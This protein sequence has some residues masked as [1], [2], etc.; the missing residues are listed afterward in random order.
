MLRGIPRLGS[1]GNVPAAATAPDRGFARIRREPAPRL[2]TTTVARSQSACCLKVATALREQRAYTD[3]VQR[4]TG[5]LSR[6]YFIARRQADQEDGRDL[7][8]SLRA[9]GSPVSSSTTSD[10][11]QHA[12]SSELECPSIGPCGSQGTRPRRCFGV[13]RSPARP[14]EGCRLTSGRR[15]RSDR[16][17]APNRH[18]LAIGTNPARE[19]RSVLPSPYIIDRQ[20]GA[21]GGS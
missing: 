9:R 2:R 6:G 15:H 21:N 13:T 4:R 7:E 19:L 12:T 10:V 16:A 8:G 1:P 18:S 5:R 14:T 3:D 11:L 20:V 17:T